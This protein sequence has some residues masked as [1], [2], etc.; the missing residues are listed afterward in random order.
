MRYLDLGDLVALA[1]EVSEVE[2]HKLVELLDDPEVEA[3][4][5]DARAPLPPHEAAARLI[6][7]MALRPLP[8][9]NR[10]LALLAALQLLALNGLDVALEPSELQDVMAGVA[11]RAL[12]APDVAAWLDPRVTVRDPLEGAFRALLTP[13]AWRAIGLALLRAYRHGRRLATPGD[14]F[15]GLFREGQG[16][17]ARAL[18]AEGGEP[19][20]LVLPGRGVPERIPAFEPETR[21]CLEQAFRASVVLGHDEVNTGHLLL[22]LLDAGHATVLPDELP[23]GVVRQRVLELV[24]S[25]ARDEGHLAGRLTR[26]AARL[27][28]AD[29][30]AAADLAEIADL[31]RIGLDRLVEMVRAWRGEN[32]LE[33]L[34][35][36]PVVARL[37]GPHRLGPAASAADDDDQMTTYLAAIARYPRLTRAQESELAQFVRE[38]SGELAS[39]S[40]R[41]LIEANLH[42][43][44]SIARTYETSDMPILDL[45]QEGNLGLMEAVRHF[46]PSKGLRF[47]TYATWWIRRFIL[48]AITR[49]QS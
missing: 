44:V 32:F 8:S 21:R 39:E 25:E 46:D 17:A 10:R 6:G 34:A 16:P 2:V 47:S 29:P 23:A 31:Q 4:L 24:D 18:G 3:L 15:L 11:S 26:V 35:R 14:L 48:E 42:L 40:R 38:V 9:G 30:E 43:V 20:P 37:L 45:I 49:R 19:G 5:A 1:M 41:R 36:E 28:T 27:R 33:A 13:D 12:D 22:G 7:L